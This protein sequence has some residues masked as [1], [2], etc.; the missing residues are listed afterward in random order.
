M[1]ELLVTAACNEDDDRAR[2]IAVRLL[3]DR[4]DDPFDFA[5]RTERLDPAVART[6]AWVDAE[7]RDRPVG[8]RRSEGR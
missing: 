3:R 2:L 4:D 8:M 1:E 7:T 5:E 6:L